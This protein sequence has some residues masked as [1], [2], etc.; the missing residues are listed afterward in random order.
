MIN[1]GGTG[2]KNRRDKRNDR[3]RK[4]KI[5]CIQETHLEN[6]KIRWILKK[7]GIGEWK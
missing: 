5:I 2:A 7:V 4:I 6:G 3:K 1:T